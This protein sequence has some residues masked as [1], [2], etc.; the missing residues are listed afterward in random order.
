MGYGIKT[1]WPIFKTEI[2]IY[3]SKANFDEK[4]L[5]D[6]MIHHLDPEIRE[7]PVRGLYG[8]PEFRVPCWSMIYEA[9]KCTL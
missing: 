9:L 1:W 4:I 8:N 2:L 3:Q 6:K 5:F 7:M